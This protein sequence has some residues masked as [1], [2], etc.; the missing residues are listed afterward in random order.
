MSKNNPKTQAA[1]YLKNKVKL[2]QNQFEKKAERTEKHRERSKKS[3]RYAFSS[4]LALARKR[5][6]VTINQ[7]YLMALYDQQEGLCALSGVRMTWATGKTAPTSI[8]ID[9]IDG[10]KGYVDGNVR[11]V[12]V[13][14]NAFRGIMND[15]ELL[16][17]AKTL[18]S[19]MESKQ[20][21]KQVLEEIAA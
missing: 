20:V 3:P 12:C 17:M 6:E 1:Y 5:A 19:T 7:D 2:Q 14:V 8:S 13:A 10:K 11:L 18:V 15:Q 9:R 4:T 21:A 16:K